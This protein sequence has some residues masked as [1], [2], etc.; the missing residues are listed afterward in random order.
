MNTV[1]I[2][3]DVTEDLLMEE[4][5]NEISVLRQEV[6]F[7]DDVEGNGLVQCV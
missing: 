4:V 5:E 3:I 2:Y 7:V 1:Q 6:V